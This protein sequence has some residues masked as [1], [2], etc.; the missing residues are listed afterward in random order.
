ML[1]NINN[2]EKL[3]EMTLPFENVNIGICMVSIEGRFLN[4]NNTFCL[5]L[6]YSKVEL[7]NLNFN[8]ITHIDDKNIG[9]SFLKQVISGEINNAVF[10][11]RYVHKNGQIVW[12]NISISLQQQENGFKYFIS[13]VQNITSRKQAEEAHKESEN[14]L[15]QIFNNITD[16]VF[17]LEVTEDCRFRI[18][19]MNTSFLGLTGIDRDCM[20][21]KFIEEAI[22]EETAGIINA[23][24]RHC[25]ETGHPIEEESELE[26]PIGKHLFLSTLI[27]LCNETGRI[28]RIVCITRDI[29]QHRKEEEELIKLSKAIEHS[30]VSIVITDSNGVIEYVNPFCTN[31]TGYKHE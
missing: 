25:V 11:K 28:H 1:S 23:K 13:Y 22:P 30:P 21:G 16:R 7:L 27:P 31:N 15:Q 20:L 18:L 29:T 6:G 9:K 2:M 4:V 26:I 12:V 5:W 8:D 10:E 24:Y 14:R 17:L 19:E 3:N